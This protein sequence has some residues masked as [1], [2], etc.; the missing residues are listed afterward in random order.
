M[1]WESIVERVM[2]IVCDRAIADALGISV[3]KMND[4]KREMIKNSHMKHKIE[5]LE[6]ENKKLKEKLEKHEPKAKKYRKKPV[7]IEAV[8][9]TTVE[10]LK[11]SFPDINIYEKTKGVEIYIQTPEGGMKISEW[12]YIIK[13]IKGEYYPYKPDIFEESYERV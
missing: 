1:Y 3:E 6:D 11:K 8:R 5:F 2:K 10:A 7:V 12:D 9:F 13:G 4:I